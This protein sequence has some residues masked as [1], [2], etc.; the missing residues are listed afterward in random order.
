MRSPIIAGLLN[1]VYLLGQATAQEQSASVPYVEVP[2]KEPVPSV[3]SEEPKPEL[4]RPSVWGE[5]TEV[6]ISLY[7][8]DL[9]EVNSADQNFAASLYYEARWKTPF[10]TH[11]GPG[12]LHRRTT[13]VWTPRLV[14]VNQQMAWPAFPGAVEI[15]PGR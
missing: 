13:E 14:I 10:L 12:P 6:E 15:L 9:D 11:E 8:I 5:P 7:M 2:A 4:E 1:L 3:L